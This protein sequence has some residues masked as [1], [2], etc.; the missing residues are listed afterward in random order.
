MPDHQDFTIVLTKDE[1]ESILSS[2]YV[3]P[4]R[5]IGHLHSGITKLQRRLRQIETDIE[6]RAKRMGSDYLVGI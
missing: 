6:E 2:L 5:P 3:S 4:Q 1:L